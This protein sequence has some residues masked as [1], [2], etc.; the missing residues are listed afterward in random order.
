MSVSPEHRPS[1]RPLCSLV[2]SVFNEEE[3]LEPLYDAVIQAVEPLNAD[4]EMIFV[5][6]GSTD[7]SYEII[8]ELHRR[9]PR[10]RALRFSRNF[11]AYAADAAGFHHAR[12][13][14][15]VQMAADLQDPPELLGPLLEKWREGYDIVWAV[16]EQRED[17]FLKR[18]LA[19]A[20]Y[21]L[22][23]RV[24]LPQYPERGTDGFGLLDRRVVDQYCRFKERNRL[25]SLLLSWSGFRQTE[26]PYHRP[27]RRAGSSKWGFA[28]RIEAAVDAFV[29]FSYLPIRLVSYLGL[30]ISLGSFGFGAYIVVQRLFFGVGGPGWPSVMAVGLF[31]GGVQLVVLGV[32]GEYI[33]RIAEEVRGRP[34]YIVMDSLG[35]EERE[36][37]EAHAD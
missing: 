29:S 12:G 6:D 18:L 5:D 35:M 22:L 30:L 15:A 14:V 8:K 19:Q 25:G 23:R 20:F 37:H 9:D 13:D 26:V 32:L 1:A 2:V 4:F 3:N 7:R 21:K 16:R 31:L 10:V 34:L 11:G 27:P 24:A 28:K 33:W 36:R 17:P